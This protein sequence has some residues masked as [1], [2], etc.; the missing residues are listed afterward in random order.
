MFWEHSRALIKPG[1]ARMQ[2]ADIHLSTFDRHVRRLV[3]L[4][5]ADGSTI[6]LQLLFPRSALDFST[7]FLFEESIGCLTP[8]AT[9]AEDKAFLNAYNYEQ[10]VVGKRGLDKLSDPRSQKSAPERF[11]L[12][13]ELPR[14]TQ[15]LKDVR[16]Q[17][18][19][20]FLPTHGA[21]GV[22]LTNVLFFQ[23]ARH[24]TVYAKL[25]KEINAAVQ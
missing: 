13:H 5:P 8:D 17:P 19:N 24:P 11:V 6:D 16:N 25:R 21:T 1:F 7:E 9:S 23:L 20:I 18:M 3:D 10:M 12:L 15:D 14:Q 2:I 4:I 22:A